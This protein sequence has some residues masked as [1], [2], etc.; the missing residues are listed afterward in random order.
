MNF[1]NH[2]FCTSH[3]RLLATKFYKFPVTTYKSLIVNSD[4][5]SSE[6]E[7]VA[8]F[9]QLLSEQSIIVSKTPT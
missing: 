7:V 4:Q 8:M 3:D 5:F 2:V 9:L 6:F 1:T